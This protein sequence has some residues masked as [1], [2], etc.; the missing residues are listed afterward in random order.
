[1]RTQG[2]GGGLNKMSSR[3]EEGFQHTPRNDRDRRGLAARSTRKQAGKYMLLQGCLTASGRANATATVGLG[4]EK[5]GGSNL[6]DWLR[7]GVHSILS[8]LSP[9][10]G[11]GTG[12]TQ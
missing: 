7:T 9:F 1:M 11:G 4:R 10:A 6:W 5:S 3:K 2:G 8:L 12:R